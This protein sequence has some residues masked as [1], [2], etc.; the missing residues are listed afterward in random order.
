MLNFHHKFIETK[1]LYLNNFVKV[2]QKNLI[3]T[4]YADVLTTTLSIALFFS[5]GFYYP[6]KINWCGSNCWVY[7]SI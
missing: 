5:N 3:F 6:F 7:P 2:A 4:I 1:E